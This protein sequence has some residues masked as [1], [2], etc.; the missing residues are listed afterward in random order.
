M[1]ICHVPHVE[2][3]SFRDVC[4]LFPVEVLRVVARLMVVFV[5]IGV[6]PDDGDVVLC[7]GAVV[8]APYGSVPR[9]VVRAEVETVGFD[10][11]LEPIAKGGVGFGVEID[12]VCRVGFVVVSANH[13]EVEVAFDAFQLRKAVHK[14]LR[15]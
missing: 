8:A 9:T 13:V 5:P 2:E 11:L 7:K 14:I 6:I 3:C 12:H 4:E 10:V 1:E 15:T